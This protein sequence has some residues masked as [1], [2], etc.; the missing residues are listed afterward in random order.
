MDSEIQPEGTLLLS[1]DADHFHVA[2]TTSEAAA[3]KSERLCWW[4]EAEL[5]LLILI[6]AGAYSWHMTE[7]PIRGEESRWTK[8]G[9]EMLQTGEW[10]TP[11]LQG[12]PYVTR[13][14]LGSWLIALGAWWRGSADLVAVR[15]PSVLATLLT[16]IL[17][18]G[19]GRGFLSRFGALTAAAAFATMG[20]VLELCRLAEN[21]AVFTFFLASALLLWHCGHTR[22]WP[23]TRTWLVGY[24]LAAL[25]ALTKGSQAPVYFVGTTVVFLTL[26]GQWRRL[27]RPAHLVGITAFAVIVLAWQLPFYRQL[28][29]PGVWEAWVGQTAIRMD[30]SPSAVISHLLSYPF[31]VL[32]SMLPWSLLLLCFA[33]RTFRASLGSL[34]PHALY[35]VTCIVVALPSCWLVPMARARYLMPLYPCFALLVGMAAQ[36]IVEAEA[37]QKL[38]RLWNRSLSL[39]V[40]IMLGAGLATLAMGGLALFDHTPLDQ[41]WGF[42][43]VYLLACILLAWTVKQGSQQPQGARAVFGLTDVNSRSVLAIAAFLGLSYSGT[44]L[45]MVMNTS[46]DMASAVARVKQQLPQGTRLVSFREANHLFAYHYRDPIEYHPWPEDAGDVDPQVDYFCFFTWARQEFPLPF[47]WDQVAVVSCHRTKTPDPDEIMIIGRRR[48]DSSTPTQAVQASNSN[49]PR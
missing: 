5:W 49:L 29:L 45:H 16:V 43:V 15:L 22:G 19:Y 39:W 10:S 32:G 21:E 28:G 14:P 44:V 17:I 33:S 41:P 24:S 36:R 6:V 7:L 3:G 26:S 30:R 34:R 42:A 47:E 48:H 4:M 13:P 38:H 12:V 31:E 25:A 40:L 20:Q 35:L 27:F 1:K 37:G 46:E 23:A 8:I 2:T 18:Y 9:C 11:R